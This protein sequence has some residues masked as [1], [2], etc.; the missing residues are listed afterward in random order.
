MEIKI[1]KE[2]SKEREYE[3]LIAS[4]AKQ[5]AMLDYVAMMT[6]VELPNEGSEV[7]DEL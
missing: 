2:I 4:Q 6:D 3:N 5:K 7:Q 1:I